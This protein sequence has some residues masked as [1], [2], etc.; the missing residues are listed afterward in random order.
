MKSENQGL[1]VGNPG[2]F[3]ARAALSDNLSMGNLYTR[4]LADIICFLFLFNF[5]L[6]KGVGITSSFIVALAIAAGSLLCSRSIRSGLFRLI[7]SRYFASICTMTLFTI[8]YA[9]LSAILHGTGDF[10]FCEALLKALLVIA[11]SAIF[12]VFLKSVFN[13]P[14][15]EILIDAF[16]IQSVIIIFSFFSP[17]FKSATDIFRSDDL[18][19]TSERY[20]GYRGLAIAGSAYYG[21]AIAYAYI[22]VLVAFHWEKW[23]IRSLPL[24]IASIILLVFAGVTAGRTAAIGL[25]FALI[26][27]IWRIGKKRVLKIGS[28]LSIFI[29][30]TLIACICTVFLITAPQ[31]HS[32]DIPP[33]LESFK[34][35]AFSFIENFNPEDIMSSTSSTEQLSEM[36]F[37]LTFD[38]LIVGDGAYT[39]SDGLYYMNTD[40]GYMRTILYFGVPGLFLIMMCQL[41][42]IRPVPN[43]RFSAIIFFLLLLIL[44]Y[45]GEALLLPMCLNT[46]ILLSQFEFHF[47]ETSN[48]DQTMNFFC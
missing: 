18:I 44:E 4:L 10:T 40:A 36:Y 39:S 29:S 27:F 30:S 25:P 32:V 46:V 43:Y 45:K 34:E 12:F 17:A 41:S 35:Y 7:R 26:V 2:S 38:Q 48:N 19:L 20:S 1:L 42:I 9:F 33:Q 6:V 21:L 15:V 31:A 47:A 14:V 11:G 28:H 13:V 22:Y 24:R 23:S 3:E 37:P 8:F 5:Q 16:I